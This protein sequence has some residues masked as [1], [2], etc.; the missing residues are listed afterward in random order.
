MDLLE[1]VASLERGG[2][3]QIGHFWSC[4]WSKEPWG[5]EL[6]PAWLVQSQQS[7]ARGTGSGNQSDAD[8]YKSQKFLSVSQRIQEIQS[9]LHCC[10]SELAGGME[11][12]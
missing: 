7:S 11:K 5:T 12:V 1:N 6:L 9:V 4:L 8:L 10:D 3:D 2:E